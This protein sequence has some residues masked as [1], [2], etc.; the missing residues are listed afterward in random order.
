MLVSLDKE[1]RVKRENRSENIRMTR[2][3]IKEQREGILVYILK[4]RNIGQKIPKK[5]LQ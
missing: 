3:N 4:K 2:V 1:N 5:M